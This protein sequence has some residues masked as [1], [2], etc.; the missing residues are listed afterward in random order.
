M[1]KR[2]GA[3]GNE[4]S[5]GSS[6]T[7]S[8][9]SGYFNRSKQPL[10]ILALIAPLVLFYELGL[11]YSLRRSQGTLT[12][13]AHETLLQFFV[14]FGVD[15]ARLS[16][17]ALALPAVALIVVMVIWQI[18]SRKPWTVHLPTVGG[19]FVESVLFAF[20]LLVMAQLI[21]RAFIPATPESI[22]QLDTFGRVAM[23]IGAG[24]YEELIFRMVVISLLHTVFVDLLRMPERW[25]IALAIAISAVLFMLYHPHQTIAQATDWRRVIFFL[26]AGT[27]FGLLYVMRG[28]GIAVGAHAFYDIAAVVLFSGD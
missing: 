25:G 20:P 10:E 5:R 27:F 23:S 9:F 12:N 26:V 22:T 15:P 17:P 19:M 24:L 4:R 21:S 1:A 18:L 13:G 6:K 11:M 16:L 3:R 8:V 7:R 14:N 28:F 2:T